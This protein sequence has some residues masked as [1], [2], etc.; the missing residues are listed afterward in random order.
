MALINIYEFV[1]NNINM[2]YAI[3]IIRKFML[4]I[5]IIFEIY[6]LIGNKGKKKNF[7]KEKPDA[8]FS[9]KGNSVSLWSKKIWSEIGAP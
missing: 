2:L 1:M 9:L 7:G 4:F 3:W 8:K 6:I 5:V